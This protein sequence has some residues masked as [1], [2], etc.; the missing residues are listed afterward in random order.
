MQKLGGGGGQ[1]KTLVSIFFSLSKQC[2]RQMGVKRVI[3][4]KSCGIVYLLIVFF[5]NLLQQQMQKS[6][7]K[8]K[9]KILGMTLKNHLHILFYFFSDKGLTLI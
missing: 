5:G 6:F 8:K 2:L 3:Y 7:F 1:S 9:K 4:L